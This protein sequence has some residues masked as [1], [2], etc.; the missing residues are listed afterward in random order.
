MAFLLSADSPGLPPTVLEAEMCLDLSVGGLLTSMHTC[1][2]LSLLAT[3]L[4]AYRLSA[5]PSSRH[6]PL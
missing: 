4:G 5:P 6:P 3:Y 2:G 1:G